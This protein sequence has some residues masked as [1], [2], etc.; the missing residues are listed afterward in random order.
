MIT[1]LEN[2]PILFTSLISLF[3]FVVLLGLGWVVR[4]RFKIGLGLFYNIFSLFTVIGV[5]VFLNH[6]YGLFKNLNLDSFIK[7]YTAVIVFFAV[8]FLTKVFSVFF[9]DYYL[10]GV[11]FIIL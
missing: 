9:W 3:A 6:K 1:W 8:V 10:D 4:T 2:S 5:W 7:W 11:K